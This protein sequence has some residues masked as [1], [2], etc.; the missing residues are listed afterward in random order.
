[1]WEHI[2]GPRGSKR[3][4]SIRIPVA[5][6]SALFTL[7]GIKSEQQRVVR[8]TTGPLAARK[9]T[10]AR[11]S[12]YGQHNGSMDLIVRGRSYVETKVA[13]DGSWSGIRSSI[14]S[15]CQCATSSVYPSAFAGGD[16]SGFFNLPPG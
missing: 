16:A 6:P 2:P 5:L 1:M 7:I 10:T 8:G 14:D 12:G 11:I 13:R 15:R 9:T 3:V 4:L